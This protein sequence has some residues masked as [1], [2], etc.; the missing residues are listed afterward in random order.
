MRERP[1]HPGAPPL[2]NCQA[3]TLQSL[4]EFRALAADWDNLWQRSDTKSPSARS[5]LVAHWTEHFAPNADFRAITVREDGRLVAALPLV[6][7]HVKRFLTVGALPQNEWTSGGDLLV[8][9]QAD[10]PRV[11]DCLVDEFSRTPWPL[12][13]LDGV[14]FEER[15][16]C[17]LQAALSRRRITTS[18]EPTDRVGQIEQAA[19]WAAFESRLDGDFRRSRRR[20]AKRLL[21]AGATE[22][23]ITRPQ[24]PDEIDSLVH[25][26]F[27]V[28]DRSWKGAAGTS[29][30]RNEHMLEFYQGQARLLADSGH[31][32]LVFL[33]H[34]ERPI[35]FAYIWRAKGIRFIAKLGYDEAFKQLGPGQTMIYLLL[36]RSYA[37]DDCPLVDFWGSLRPWNAD[38]STRTY[39][40]GRLVLAPPR[41]ASRG[42]LFAYKRLRKRRSEA[43]AAAA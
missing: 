38:W 16:W 8:D 14:A 28:E 10:V 19:D 30:L 18:L 26:G 6:S 11:L 21:E 25:Q 4:T 13:W 37:E 33:V 23:K 43:T 15:R 35:A 12:V 40:V 3:T 36:Q 31:L 39:P 17:E 27:D 20:Y 34:Q 22:L 5:H 32:E 2:I 1:R 42:L 24:S 7:Q 29:V 9:P 41:L